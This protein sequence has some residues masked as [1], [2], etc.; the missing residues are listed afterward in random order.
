MS[1]PKFI[2]LTILAI[3][4]LLSFGTTVAEE[5]CCDLA[6]AS[7]EKSGEA[8]TCC[9]VPATGT[10]ESTASLWAGELL[11]NAIDPISGEPSTPEFFLDHA[12]Q[13]TNVYGR[14]YFSGKTSLD[15]ASEMSTKELYEQAF[16]RRADGIFAAYG[17]ARLALDNKFCP[18]SGVG[19]TDDRTLSLDKAMATNCTAGSCSLGDGFKANYNA[20]EIGACCPSCIKMMAAAPDKFLANLGPEMDAAFAKL[21][22]ATD[23][24]SK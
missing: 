3:S 9:A 5:P 4:V 11:R 20:V 15:S 13:D 22:H 8:P 23:E 12:D 24:E 7:S 1:S 17:S 21:Q 14:I 10:L 16:L 19:V 18:V 2:P 6:G